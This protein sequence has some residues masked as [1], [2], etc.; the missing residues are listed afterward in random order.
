MTLLS[1]TP[2]HA[3]LG[4]LILGVATAG[5][6]LTTGRVLGI[7]GAVK[8]LV[9]NDTSAWRFAFLLG[10]GLGGFALLGFMPGAFEALPASFTVWRAALGGLLVG[11]GSSLGNGCT[12]GHGICGSARLSPRSFAYTATFMAAGM[13][14]ATATG[15]ASALAIAPVAPSL[16]LPGLH[17]VQLA[18]S[19]AAAGLATFGALAA[20]ARIFSA[21][22][23]SSASISTV[24]AKPAN[25]AGT[26]SALSA[27]PTSSGGSGGSAPA[28]F[29]LTA[30]AAAGALFALGL[31]FSGMTHPTK[32]V[33][34]LS[35][36]FPGWDL[37]LPFVMGGAVLV[38]MAA[39]QGIMRFRLLPKPLLCSKFQIPTASSIDARLLLGGLLFGA[40]WGVSGMCPGPAL[41]SL[42]HG[43]PQVVAYLASFLG[44]MWAEGRVSEWMAQRGKSAAAA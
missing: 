37:S 35:V 25:A 27:I 32:V 26:S 31:G 39:F 42:V 7:S 24:S 12:S 8:G 11:L 5:K 15:T 10:M 29:E 9:N 30:E 2:A 13:A 6:L 1:F 20:A 14:A 17:E 3:A 18:A 23:S 44:G 22:S 43:D 19:L 28:V 33:G 36:T 41:V 38:A 40:G 4:G 21:R 16:V 34:F